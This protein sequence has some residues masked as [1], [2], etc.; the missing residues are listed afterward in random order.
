MKGDIED[1][2]KF[3]MDP[4]QIFCKLLIDKEHFN[5]LS[6]ELEKLQK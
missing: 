6:Q 1:I 2:K 3:E 4:L 5:P